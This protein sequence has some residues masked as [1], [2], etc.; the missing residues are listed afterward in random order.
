M[1]GRDATGAGAAPGRTNELGSIICVRCG[2]GFACDGVAADPGGG[3]DPERGPIA[4]AGFCMLG[5]SCVPGAFFAGDAPAFG[6]G[7]LVPVRGRP[8]DDGLEPGA[9]GGI[10]SPAALRNAPRCE[11]ALLTARGDT[12]GAGA[13]GSTAPGAPDGGF[14]VVAGGGGPYG[15]PI[16]RDEGDAVAANGFTGGPIAT[17]GGP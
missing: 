12:L 14:A 6:G 2:G 9:L 8:G 16:A 17:P 3:A 4:A 5:M 15:D 11:S 7:G 10:L 1:D 13:V